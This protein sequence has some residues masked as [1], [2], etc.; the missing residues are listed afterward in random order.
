MNKLWICRKITQN[1]QFLL[2]LEK[3]IY[4][5]WSDEDTAVINKY[6]QRFIENV[7]AYPNKK[8]PLPGRYF[9]FTYVS[10]IT[11]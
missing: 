6:F 10:H 9:L 4:R 2:F 11:T 1:R 3:R 5:P 8:S 7:G